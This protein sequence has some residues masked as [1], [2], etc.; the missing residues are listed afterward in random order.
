MKFPVFP[1]TLLG[2]SLVAGSLAL[3]SLSFISEGVRAAVSPRSIEVKET[4]GTVT[5][6]G[7]PVK[8]GDR[9]QASGSLTTN[10]DARVV[11]AMEDG[12]G[13]VQV[14]ENTNV[15]VKTL[16]TSKDGSK[17]TR[18]YL[19]KGQVNAKVRPFTNPNSNFEVETPG[20]IAG[21]RGTEFGVTVGSNGKT[22][23]STI[24]GKVAFSARGKTVL[25]E[26][27]YSALI[28]PGQAPTIPKVTTGD[29]RLKLQVLSVTGDGQVRVT[30]TVDPINLVLVNNQIVDTGGEGQLDTVVP[31]PSNRQLRLVVRNPLGNQQ[32]YELE[33]P[34]SAGT[35]ENPVN[36]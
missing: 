30:G 15:Q 36:Q 12:I 22:G 14:S 10:F 18:L 5:S 8:A 35:S 16:K 1:V 20:G 27:G 21:T 4:N 26:P 33:I 19:D 32:V 13:T 23:L 2:L 11:L 29:T 24:R 25:V 9:L 31:I 28:V 7:K 34:N 3:T 17:Q 6:Q